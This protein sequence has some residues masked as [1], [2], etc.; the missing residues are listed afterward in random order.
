[1]PSIKYMY[2]YVSL[3]WTNF[4]L[5]TPSSVMYFMDSPLLLQTLQLFVIDGQTDIVINNPIAQA[6]SL[7][8]K[9]RQI[10]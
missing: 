10:N 3:F 2:M 4:Y 5:P 9:G 8:R 6:R 1:M 7:H